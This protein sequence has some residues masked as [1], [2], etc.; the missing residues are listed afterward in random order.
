M[1]MGKSR[2]RGLGYHKYL[3]F[4]FMA[5]RAH[6]VLTAQGD[7]VMDAIQRKYVFNKK[8]VSSTLSVAPSGPQFR[9]P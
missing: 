4:R 1:S 3:N 5:A 6:A 7:T 8:E 9:D 2:I